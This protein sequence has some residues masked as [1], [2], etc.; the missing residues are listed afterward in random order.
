VSHAPSPPLRGRTAA[1]TLL[2]AWWV[3]FN[4]RAV[5]LG[6]PPALGHVRDDLG[7]SYTASG[8]LTSLPV[9]VLGVLA[10]PGA[11][12][13]RRRGGHRVVAPSPPPRTSPPRRR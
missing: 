3:G 2:I 9:L 11:A 13:V 12:L 6:V 10:F 7:L 4:L 5:L 1:L 8:L